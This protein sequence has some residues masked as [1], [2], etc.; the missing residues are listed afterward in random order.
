MILVWFGFV[1]WNDGEGDGDGDGDGEGTCL[2]A[3]PINDA[4]IMTWLPMVTLLASSRW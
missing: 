2:T 4:T 3:G 1:G